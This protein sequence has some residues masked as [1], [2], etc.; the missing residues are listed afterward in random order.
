MPLNFVGSTIGVDSYGVSGGGDDR[1]GR[2][3]TTGAV[4]L[5]RVTRPRGLFPDG[6]ISSARSA[7]GG[8]LGASS[9]G[10]RDVETVRVPS[11]V[12]SYAFNEKSRGAILTTGVPPFALRSSLR[13]FGSVSDKAVA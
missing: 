2:E 1:F 3:S 13:L 6:R 11:R 9:N 4:D 5:T 8:T 12:F 10:N 7:T